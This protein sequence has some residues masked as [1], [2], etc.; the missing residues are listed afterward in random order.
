MEKN[1]KPKFSE[2]VGDLGEPVTSIETYQNP[3]FGFLNVL[4]I[5]NGRSQWFIAKEVAYSLGYNTDRVDRL[6][7]RYVQPSEIRVLK[8]ANMP[9]INIYKISKRGLYIISEKGIFQL[10]LNSTLPNAIEYKIWVSEVIQTIHHTGY[11]KC[12]IDEANKQLENL[13]KTSTLPQFDLSPYQQGAYVDVIS[14]NEF[15]S[16]EIDKD[17]KLRIINLGFFMLFR[18]TYIALDPQYNITH[19]AEPF[20][21]AFK[22]GGSQATS[23][24]LTNIQ[25][26]L[27]Q[28]SCGA[29]LIDLES[30]IYFYYPSNYTP[31]YNIP[32]GSEIQKIISNNEKQTKIIDAEVIEN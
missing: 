5:N 13:F 4:V 6:L 12:E 21:I 9:N 7:K 11:Y 20:D 27:S 2:I 26:I 24:I 1:L 10:V 19:K 18:Q 30:W 14:F 23:A 3:L 8:T 28:L 25:F 31:K 17:Y 32:N 16:E 22:F 29:S 15:G